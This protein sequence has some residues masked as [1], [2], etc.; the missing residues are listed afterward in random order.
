MAAP[1]EKKVRTS[2]PMVIGSPLASGAGGCSGICTEISVSLPM[3]CAS[4]KVRL[5]NFSSESELLETC[6]VRS[7]AGEIELCFIIGDYKASDGAAPMRELEFFNV[8]A[9]CEFAYRGQ[10][11]LFGSTWFTAL[12]MFH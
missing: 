5:C 10:S 11:L 2:V 7:L 1:L 4:S 9:L 6:R 12:S 3:V 8:Y